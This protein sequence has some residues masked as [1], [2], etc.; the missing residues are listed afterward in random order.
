MNVACWYS[1]SSYCGYLDNNNVCQ[2]YFIIMCNT[3]F[4][5]FNT[6]PSCLIDDWSCDCIL[7]ALCHLNASVSIAL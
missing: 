1:C 6:P 4:A 5:I 3:R 2:C 7:Q